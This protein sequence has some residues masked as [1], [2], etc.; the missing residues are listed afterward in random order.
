MAYCEQTCDG[1][2]ETE[3]INDN[4]ETEGDIS[5]TS[6]KETLLNT[7]QCYLWKKMR[8]DWK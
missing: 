2:I 7:I 5:T 4:D 6:A 3:H 8:S 1:P